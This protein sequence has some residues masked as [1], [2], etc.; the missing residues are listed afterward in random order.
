[1]KRAKELTNRDS[2]QMLANGRGREE[3]V[4]E[5]AKSADMAATAS[6]NYHY[7]RR[8]CGIRWRLTS[9]RAL[10]IACLLEKNEAALV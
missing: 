9:Q 8:V 6:L 5:T 4:E 10:L 1:M 3:P 7:Q 2:Q